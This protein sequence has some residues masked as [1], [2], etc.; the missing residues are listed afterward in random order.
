MK[1]IFVLGLVLGSLSLN[2]SD[3]KI[4]SCLNC[5]GT[6]FEKKALGKSKIVKNM[7]EIEIS[8]AL[9]G[10]KEETYGGTMKGIEKPN[11]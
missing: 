6:N 3:F 2:A 4:N 8:K 1:K 7:S 10:Y 9:K 5:H 11:C